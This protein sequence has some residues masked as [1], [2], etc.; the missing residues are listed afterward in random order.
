MTHSRGSMRARCQWL[1]LAAAV[2]LIPTGVLW[3]LIPGGQA[4]RR[5]PLACTL[6]GVYGGVGQAVLV[7]LFPILAAL[8]GAISM[9]D[10]RCDQRPLST[11]AKVA[12]AGVAALL[13]LEWLATTGRP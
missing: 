13:V 2:Y 3:L 5:P 12:V 11:A 9:R 10:A 4:E 7:L 6:A 8:L 1:G